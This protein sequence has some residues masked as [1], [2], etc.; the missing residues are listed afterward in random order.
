MSPCCFG[1]CSYTLTRGPEVST[2]TALWAQAATARPY[3]GQASCRQGRGVG[4]GSPCGRKSR[5]SSPIIWRA[6]DCRARRLSGC[7]RDPRGSRYRSYKRRNIGFRPLFGPT[8]RS[9][10]RLQL[11]IRRSSGHAIRHVIRTNRRRASRLD[12]QREIGRHSM[13]A[14][15]RKA[16]QKNSVHD[17]RSRASKRAENRS[18]FG[19]DNDKAYGPKRRRIHPATK[20]FQAIRI[21][22]N[23][24]LM[25]LEKGLDDIPELLA[26]GGRLCVM[27]YHS[28]ED[29]MVKRSFQ[30]RK[31]DKDRWTVITR[32]PIVPSDDE[33]RENPRARSPRCAC[34]KRLRRDI[35]RSEV[36]K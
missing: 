22:V 35:Q 1:K 6:C 23:R 26:P 33:I 32:K 2:W 31:R 29:R 21:A 27:S 12:F 8:G 13:G 9:G 14:R 5:E 25:N 28:L 10:K 19:Q 7:E 30:S 34:W 17:R 15:G 18:R 16:L 36:S 24:E 11:S 4:F 3:S 20:T